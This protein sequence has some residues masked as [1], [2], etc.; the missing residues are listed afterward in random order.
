VNYRDDP[1]GIETPRATTAPAASKDPFGI[2]SP[3]TAVITSSVQNDPFGLGDLRPAPTGASLPVPKAAPAGVIPAGIPT[4]PFGIET[5]SVPSM[6]GTQP[7]VSTAMRQI[8]MRRA[9]DMANPALPSTVV[10]TT[11]IDPAGFHFTPGGG[12]LNDLLSATP[13]IEPIN[14]S[15]GANLSGVSSANISGD[16]P[17]NP[18]EP[19]AYHPNNQGS[20]IAAAGDT[21]YGFG[22]EALATVGRIATG[23]A[24][25]VLAT[26][27]KLGEAAGVPDTTV[28][29]V[30]VGPQVPRRIREGL[31]GVETA[32]GE[33]V[34]SSASMQEE[35][36]GLVRKAIAFPQHVGAAVP[37]IAA[38]GISA[39]AAPLTVGLDTFS[40]NYQQMR[41]RA[42]N[43][44]DPATGQRLYTP[45]QAHSAALIGTAADA[46]AQ[47]VLMRA[48]PFLGNNPGG[49]VSRVGESA[50][51]GGAQAATT[52]LAEA[53]IEQR[54][55]DAS[56][57][58]RAAEG[59]KTGAAFGL[60]PPL[61]GRSGKLDPLGL[62]RPAESAA[63]PVPAVRREPKIDPLGLERPAQVGE[64]PPHH[65][66]PSPR[67]PEAPGATI[68]AEP[69]STP[70]EAPN[71]PGLQPSPARGNVQRG[72]FSKAGLERALIEHFEAAGG[73]QVD[74]GFA[75]IERSGGRGFTF[76]GKLPGEVREF[77]ESVPAARRLFRVTQDRTKAG[78]E[79]A[80]VE[81]GDDAYFA[82]A[83]RLSTRRLDQALAEARRSDDPN[84]RFLA[85]LHKN[86]PPPRERPK[87]QVMEPRQLATGAEFEIN[88]SKFQVVESEHGYR[89][90]KDG[91]DYPELPLDELNKVPVDKGT[92]RQ[93]EPIPA[94]PDPLGIDKP[95]H[96]P[97]GIKTPQPTGASVHD[98]FG[99]E[100]P[101][102][103]GVSARDPLGIDLPE[104]P[105]DGIPF[106]RKEPQRNQGL[107]G[108]TVVEPAGIGAQGGLFHEPVAAAPVGGEK[109]KAS[110]EAVKP[111]N[112][113]ELFGRS[114]R[115]RITGGVHRGME[116]E[117]VAELGAGGVRVQVPGEKPVILRPDQFQ[118]IGETPASRGGGA[119]ADLKDE[120]APPEH[121]L[122]EAMADDATEPPAEESPAKFDALPATVRTAAGERTLRPVE[123]PEMVSLAEELMGK[124][125]E[126][127]NLPRARGA[128]HPQGPGR[129]VIDENTPKDPYQLAKTMAHEIGHLVDYLSDRTMVRGNVLG[130][131]RSAKPQ[132]VNGLERLQGFLKNTFGDGTPTNKELRDELMAV[133]GW[134]R[135]GDMS[136]D[137]RKSS[138]ELYADAV[139]VLLN[140]PG[141]LQS[142]APKFFAEFVK[143]LDAKPDVFQAYMDL[144][145]ALTG[146]PEQLAQ[147]RRED[148]REMFGKGEGMIW[149]RAKERLVSQ[150]DMLSHI[151]QMLWDS[152]RPITKRTNQL[153]RRI[154]RT[155]D[156]LSAHYALDE[157]THS[158]NVNH[159]MLK[160][161]QRQVMEPVLKAGMDKAT[162]DEYLMMDRILNGRADIGNPAGHTAATAKAQLANLERTLG[163]E[164]WSTLKQSIARFHDI[165]FAAAERAVEVG[166][167]NRD[168]FEN[169]IR[170]NKDNYAAFAVTDYMKD[171]V[172]AGVRQQLGTFKDIGSP[173]TATIMK[174][175]TLNRLNELQVAKNAT[176]DW[177]KK[178]YAEEWPKGSKIDQHHAEP[179]PPEG[180]ANL[181][182]LEDG[183][184]VA[185]PVDK[186]IKLMFDR[187][188][189]G[190]LAEFGR[191]LSSITYK[192][193]HPLFVT[194]S[195]GF[196]AFNLI[197]DPKRTYVNLGATEGVTV[198]QLLKAYWQAK[199]PAWR[200]ARGIDDPLIDRM[201]EEK[202]LSVP[203]NKLLLDADSPDNTSHYDRLLKQYGLKDPDQSRSRIVGGLRAM[204]SG[205]E[206]IGDFI[207]TTPKVG[208]FN[209]LES[210][211]VGNRARSYQV[212]NYV[213][214]PNLRRR[215][216]MTDLTNG[217]FMYSN[218]MIQGLRGDA[219]VATNPSTRGGWTMRRF[220]IDFAPK[221]LMKSAAMG[222][223]GPGMQK[224]M[225]NVPSYDLA[226]YTII[227]LG[228]TGEGDERKTVYLRIPHDETGRLMSSIFWAAINSDETGVWK[229]VQNV[230]NYGYGGLPKWSP[231]ITMAATW[232]DYWRG[233][234]PTDFRD[235]PIIGDDEFKTGGAPAFTDMLRWQFEQFGVVSEVGR[236]F[237]PRSDGLHER[238][239]LE[240]TLNALP[241][242]NRLIKVSNQGIR[243]D[244]WNSIAAE[245]AEAARFRL[246]LPDEART[247]VKERYRLSR[248]DLDTLSGPDLQRL[249][250]L[251]DFY[252]QYLKLTSGMKDH[253]AKGFPQNAEKLKRDLAQAAHDAIARTRST[254]P[255]DRQAVVESVLEKVRGSDLDPQ[256]QAAALRNAGITPPPDLELEYELSALRKVKNQ[257]DDARQQAD[258]LLRQA[259]PVSRTD[260][261]RAV[262]MRRQAVQLRR[263][264]RM[265]PR[266][267]TRLEALERAHTSI[268]AIRQRVREGRVRQE[269]G[270]R[271]IQSISRTVARRPAA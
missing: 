33:A 42:E 68:A 158:N 247:L 54:A 208:G 188:D 121:R 177:M 267:A 36:Q 71:A 50:L 172:P 55:P 138:V 17:T 210:K 270:E 203:F 93:P 271:Q 18:T 117:I 4:D 35:Q 1:F 219:E 75:A 89:A 128:F 109:I 189:I 12:D 38:G 85:A 99:I 9:P 122:R 100:Q 206:T 255:Q 159:L 228:M 124:V 150:W 63:E 34:P 221:I 106:S 246:G 111:E 196:Q 105:D 141:E 224:M 57:F 171:W 65:P 40:S 25:A 108:Q 259:G 64:F 91:A 166:S 147:R 29:G 232:G 142:R 263:D 59:T 269:L 62:E 200:R 156:A 112:T 164:K 145:D 152:A 140:S 77:I 216:L 66:E 88:G 20:L 107:F 198:A 60:I 82:M 265:N 137:Y 23:G 31:E 180:K 268:R 28:L 260:P 70:V 253:I 119:L 146:T 76:F 214:T 39:M 264:S 155:P 53:G 48:M 2:E 96:D 243:E 22:R 249:A 161:M 223:F 254:A 116:G 205:V 27:E 13:R 149:E 201:L 15:V 52:P 132:L 37:H 98:P 134:W 6:D 192:V 10:N 215:G 257:A 148:L 157:L 126:I 56:F 233:V 135:P 136:S 26:S 11:L 94:R 262:E 74:E 30:P 220:A 129:I 194:F 175:L 3:R 234:N 21:A 45:E 67:A 153:V 32:V 80:R 143:H 251:D 5:P 190:W 83:E 245:E 46:F 227:P 239:T 241:G 250:V 14:P 230:W 204:L 110:T 237:T 19:P 170:P 133:S 92:L 266:D 115:V 131:V 193:W 199:G 151:P 51:I 211:G 47:A 127:K 182:I 144:Q 69:P 258:S 167:Y 120:A 242:L 236:S 78:G 103:A 44:I 176:R 195:P 202:A 7:L 87:Q 90:L 154:G 118:R 101:H 81:M 229:S 213:G 49:L 184:P 165:V 24:K 163:P 231:P 114:N 238:N 181:I 86:L 84:V 8:A 123:M 209:I 207:E 160:D 169:Q 162:L 186:W 173:F 212:R 240:V 187:H 261:A 248:L 226:N 178:Y 97:F 102:P 183:K 256:R 130:R 73:K 104:P 191:K 225:Q 174:T 252:S 16:L 179:S 72:T 197:R 61:H 113:A 79:D 168:V 217:V 43:A 222:A 139:S 244:Q 185:Y 41:H 235:S 218:A 58:K 125:P 95:A